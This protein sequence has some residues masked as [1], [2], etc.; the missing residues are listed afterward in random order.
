M[1]KPRWSA[2]RAWQTLARLSSLPPVDAG[3]S[4]ASGPMA[5]DR[6]MGLSPQRVNGDWRAT[7]G[8]EKRFAAVQIG[9]IL[10]SRQD[11]IE[12]V[13]KVRAWQS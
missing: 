3:A 6:F 11:T 1:K 7:G 13:V 2:A 8:A 12:K 5:H 10:H 4:L 9:P